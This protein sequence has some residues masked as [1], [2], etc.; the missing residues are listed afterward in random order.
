MNAAKLCNNPHSETTNQLLEEIKTQLSKSQIESQRFKLHSMNLEKEWS[1]KYSQLEIR[2]KNKITTHLNQIENLK[3]KMAL[4]FF[5][6]E[7]LQTTNNKTNEELK[8]LKK[9]NNNL[10]MREHE[11]ERII[12]ELKI[13]NKE[14]QKNKEVEFH[15]LVQTNTLLLKSQN[16]R[17]FQDFVNKFE[18]EKVDMLRE[19]N[20]IKNLIELREGQVEDLKKKL[21]LVDTTNIELRNQIH[22]MNELKMNSSTFNDVHA[23]ILQKEKAQL[24]SELENLKLD[25]EENN[26]I[27]G[28]LIEDLRSQ[29]ILAK[30]E[31]TGSL[32]G[33]CQ[34]EDIQKLEE[35]INQLQI[36]NDEN[37]LRISCL[38]LRNSEL[39]SSLAQQ[40]LEKE[41]LKLE[42]RTLK[43]EK[44]KLD[45]MQEEIINGSNLQKNEPFFLENVKL[46]DFSISLPNIHRK[47]ENIK[48]AI[49]I[50]DKNDDL[51]VEDNE[52]F[53]NKNLAT[54]SEKNEENSSFLKNVEEERI[55]LSTTFRKGNKI[56]I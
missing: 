51:M 49:P 11:N 17:E 9:E 25:F 37:I 47:H 5:E 54:F 23:S 24:K 8:I 3:E 40:E 44:V 39:R 31:K 21:F 12:E 14:F 22:Q 32:E 53:E 27:K 41:N 19:A 55:H 56:F 10:L 13:N 38:E 34:Y 2:S 1:E 28:R 16:E 26:E 33:S 46:E 43:I 6:L 18:K 48:H 7:R 15:N 4:L 52:Q 45:Q 50:I 20:K 30:A 29:L 36:L 42:V 35:K